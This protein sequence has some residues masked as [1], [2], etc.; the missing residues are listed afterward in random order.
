[1]FAVLVHSISPRIQYVFKELIE[2][3]HGFSVSFYTEQAPFKEA[4]E[5][6][7]IQYLT[8]KKAQLPGFFVQQQEFMTQ[9]GVDELFT[10]EIGELLLTG[11]QKKELLYNL[12]GWERKT[13]E[14]QDVLGGFLEKPFPILFPT[15]DDLG[16]D[17][18]AMAFWFLSRYEE[19][20]SFKGDNL[21]RFTFKESFLGRKQIDS[22]PAVDIAQYVFFNFVGI[23]ISL[24]HK[25]NIAATV[26]IDMVFRFRKKGLFRTLGGFIKNPKYIIDRLVSLVS[27][28]DDFAPEKTVIPFL[29]S[30]SHPDF[31]SRVFVL[32]S[33]KKD[34]INKQVLLENSSVK[35]QI[36]RLQ[37]NF[38]IGLHPSFS[39]NLNTDWSAEKEWLEG[40]I[41]KPV[42]LARLHYVRLLFPKSY[43]AL[44]ELKIKEDWSMGF[45]ES[46]GFRAGTSYPFNWFNLASE[47]ETGLVV[48]PFQIMDVAC[49]NYM[50]LSRENSSSKGYDLKKVVKLF[51][52]TFCFIVHNESLSEKEGWKGWKRVF[53]NWANPNVINL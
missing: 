13:K 32:S 50:N 6:I 38:K 29:K 34:T 2:R 28:L 9:N 36:K 25:F 35:N 4:S 16:F 41:D 15:K 1:M 52:G 42:S 5:P 30:T 20:Q 21:G 19:Y 53:E 31:T 22:L 45:A 40:V 12:P 48:N 47:K 49:K 51:G 27:K 39:N 43:S 8:Q 26:D 10:P 14:E 37:A 17:F 11:E 33:K 3:R 7:K 24:Y 23:P 18:F 44:C 46:V